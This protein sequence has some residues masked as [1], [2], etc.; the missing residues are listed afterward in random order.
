MSNLTIK[1]VGGFSSLLS[2][3]HVCMDLI[4]ASVSGYLNALMLERHFFAESRNTKL[5]GSASNSLLK[6]VNVEQAAESLSVSSHLISPRSFYMHHGIYL[7][8]GKVAHYSGFSSSFKPGPIEV[9][10]L[11]S[12][13]NGKPVWMLQEQCEYSSEEIA[14]RARSRIGESQYKILSNN[15]EHFCS[16]CISGRSYSAQVNAYLHCPRYLFSLISALQP[17]FIA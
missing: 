7:G 2:T 15:C 12:F 8:G 6:L 14:K 17:N 9:T 4:T 3:M 13:A 1:A 5:P 10:D 16:W 11:E